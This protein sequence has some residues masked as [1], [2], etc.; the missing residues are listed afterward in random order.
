MC[1]NA[2]GEIARDEW[3]KAA[4]LRP[5][6]ELAEFVVMPN[7]MH[8]VIVIRADGS[9]GGFWQANYQY[10]PNDRQSV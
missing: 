1:L 3:L 2:W 10:D 6:I 5:N 9:G 7:H 8:G 4:L